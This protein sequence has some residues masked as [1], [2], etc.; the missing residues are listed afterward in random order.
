MQKVIVIIGPTAVGKTALSLELATKLNGEIISADSMQI[1]KGL[2]IGTA[3]LS[4]EE[5]NGIPHHLIDIRSFNETYNAWLFVND[6]RKKIDEIFDRNKQPII[7]GGTNLY[8]SAL[9]NNYDFNSGIGEKCYECKHK[10]EFVVFAVNIEPRENLYARI[11]KRVDI[12]IEQ[13]LLNEV[14]A[15]KKQGLT[16]DSQAGKSIGYRELLCYLD[17]EISLDLAIEKIKQ[18]SRNFA[19]R[20]LT[21]LRS[22]KNIFWLDGNDLNNNIQHIINC[23][24]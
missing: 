16:K 9:I 1:Y 2:D 21:W 6:C 20:Q 7:V 11:N 8:V 13:G 18:H 10:F 15:L 24:N 12:M 22:M 17:N 14:I 5:M 19:K 4:A 3:K 23:L